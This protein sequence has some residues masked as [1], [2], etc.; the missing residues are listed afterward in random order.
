M[1][2]L[3]FRDFENA[4]SLPGFPEKALGDTFDMSGFPE[5][6]SPFK[7]LWAFCSYG[8]MATLAVDGTLPK[9]S[10][11]F[12]TWN[13]F[14]TPAE[15]VCA[16]SYHLAVGYATDKFPLYL[17][18]IPFS[19][20]QLSKLS[21]FVR[22][23]VSTLYFVAIEDKYIL[24]EGQ[25]KAMTF[26]KMADM[27]NILSLVPTFNKNAFI[28]MAYTAFVDFR[29]MLC[30]PRDLTLCKILTGRDAF[31]LLGYLSFE[32]SEKEA[33]PIF[34]AIFQ[35]MT[36]VDFGLALERNLAFDNAS[37]F[38]DIFKKAALARAYFATH[39]EFL[40]PASSPKGED[41]LQATGE[42]LNRRDRSLP[43]C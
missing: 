7:W 28:C 37:E 27:A 36:D 22:G 33:K 23:E 1:I 10:W 18:C 15:A 17:A 13:L 14:E 12:A 3:C 32:L 42:P 24:S 40:W 4:P 6:Q 2:R 11:Y 34:E 26:A 38:R 30:P 8:E 41:F 43:S 16:L 9:A 35:R 19:E 21:V 25:W 20:T 5:G 39:G 31:K 29:Q